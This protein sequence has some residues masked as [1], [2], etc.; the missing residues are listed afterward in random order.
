MLHIAREES[1][2]NIHSSLESSIPL[3]IIDRPGNYAGPISFFFLL[4]ALRFQSPQAYSS[5]SIL[6]SESEQ[7]I[8]QNVKFGTSMGLKFE[9]HRGELIDVEIFGPDNSK[10]YDCKQESSGKFAFAATS[11]GEYRYCFSNTGT[12]TAKAVMFDIKTEDNEDAKL[13]ETI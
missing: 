3:T 6:D 11:D 1:T 12:V 4:L 5:L 10:I 13:A 2:V 8:S 9:I 7:C